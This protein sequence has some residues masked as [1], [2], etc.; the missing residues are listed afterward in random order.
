MNPIILY[1]A[2]FAGMSLFIRGLKSASGARVIW[3]DSGPLG[4]R[5]DEGDGVV[6]LHD[7]ARDELVRLLAAGRQVLS[8]SIPQL[9]LGVPVIHMD[10]EGPARVMA[11]E[12]VRQGARRLVYWGV[13]KPF[14]AR[15]SAGVRAA[16][17]AACIPFSETSS[18]EETLECLTHGPHPVGL[19]CMND[20]RCHAIAAGLHGSGIMI[21]KDVMLGGYDNLPPPDE[22]WSVPLTT[23]ILPLEEQGALAGRLLVDARAGTPIAHRIHTTSAPRVILRTSTRRRSERP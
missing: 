8:R 19:V 2:P 9:Q 17:H 5:V 14:S 4:D 22:P 12:M 18:P 23:V 3:F 1:G 11:E 6:F 10:D 15:R 21:P 13:T 7:E 16:A 20:E